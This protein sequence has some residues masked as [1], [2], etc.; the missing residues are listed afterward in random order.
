MTGQDVAD[1][2]AALNYHLRP[3]RP[4]HT[5]PGPDRPPLKVDGVFGAKTD[6]RLREFQRLNRLTVD[7]KA[8]PITT[9][10]FTKTKLVTVKI[11]ISPQDEAPV[12]QNAA[13]FRP[14]GGSANAFAQIPGL[15]AQAALGP[16]PAKPQPLI[17][18]VR[19]QNMQVQIGGNV[20]LA[21]I[22]GPGDPSKALFL[23][24]QFSWVEQRDGRHLELALGAQ[25][26]K[27]LTNETFGLSTTNSPQ[28][29][30]GVTVADVVAIDKANLHLFSPSAQVSFQSN[31]EGSVFKS[32]TVGASVQNQIA[33]DFVKKGNNPVFSLFLQQQLG[34]TYDFTTRQGAIAPSFLAGA[35]WQTSFF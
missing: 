35:T 2:Q 25:F 6:A 18:P 28:V 14:G 17:A 20:T 8:G 15:L 11:P 31:F 3:P 33:W 16:S 12:A 29:F 23:A 7:G 1:L 13:F 30:A 9:P 5:P 4:P 10:L 26:A 27:P 34:W 24:V 22:L 32:V 21:P 19:L